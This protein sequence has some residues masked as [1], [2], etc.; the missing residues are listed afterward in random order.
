ML[1]RAGFTIAEGLVALALLGVLGGATI[2]LLAATRRSYEAQ[3]SRMDVEANLRAASAVIPAELAELDPSD[4]WGSDLIEATDSSI[5]YG[6]PRNVSF[7]CEVALD[8]GSTGRVVVR[9]APALG[10]RSPD[11]GRDS[12]ALFAAGDASMGED[13]YWLHADL[14]AVGSA[15]CPDGTP[16]RTLDLTDV[17][18]SGALANVLPG[19]AARG[20][21][22]MRL[23]TYLDMYRDRW[24]GLRG[25]VKAIGWGTVQPVLGPLDEGGLVFRYLG[26]DGSPAVHAAAAAAIQVRVVGRSSRPVGPAGDHF[27]DTLDLWIALRN[28]RQP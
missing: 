26:A 3:V 20:L 18:P 23:E 16:G 12:M 27:T 6:A 17:T 19:A 7:V 28:A 21:E 9:E 15:D 22:V 24:L 4:P 11:P 25:H 1:S 5:T 14:A 2:R 13:D 10:L 8:A